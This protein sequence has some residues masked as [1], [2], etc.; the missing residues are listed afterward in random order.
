MG[1]F[2]SYILPL[3]LLAGAILLGWLFKVV[4][5]HRLKTL[6]S[7]T[8]WRGDDVVISAFQSSILF[9][10]ILGGLFLAIEQLPEQVPLDKSA[11]STFQVIILVLFI[12]SLSAA[13]SR[14]AVGLME[15]YAESTGG[16]FPSTSMFTNLARIF[17]MTIGLLVIFQTVGISITPVLTALGV[18]GLA[19]SLALKDTLSDLFAG[20]HIILSRKLKPGDLVELDSGQRGTVDNITWRQTTLRDR[21]NNLIVIPNGKLS[22]AIMI[23]YDVPLKEMIVRVNCGVAYDSDLDRVEQIVLEIARKVVNTTPG[24]VPDSEVGMNF[25]N[26]GDSSIDFR[27]SMRAQDY[28]GQWSVAHEFIKRLHKRFNEEG[29]E[30]PFPIRTVYQKN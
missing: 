6:A 14:V 2:E 25:I 18:G 23:N 7:K 3:A 11:I 16:V 9:W 13:L 12:L 17:I 24:G 15:M 5:S 8:K 22:A 21:K 1:N 27:V 26:F 30:I 20:L 4:I 29:I 19:V 10:F 28:S